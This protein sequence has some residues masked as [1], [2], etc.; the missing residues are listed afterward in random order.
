MELNTIPYSG[1]GQAMNDLLGGQ[2]D[3][4]GDQTTQT[5]PMVKDD[6]VKVFGLTTL[7]GPV[8]LPD[9]PMLDEQ[10]LKVFEVEVRHG[11]YAPKGPPAPVWNK[12]MSPCAWPLRIRLSSSAWV[13][14]ARTLRRL[15]KSCQS[16]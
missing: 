16:A 6:R 13:S 10:G 2:A 11:M 4:L 12:S 8:V 7:K 3:L 15:T 1:T 5:V 9:V 14:W